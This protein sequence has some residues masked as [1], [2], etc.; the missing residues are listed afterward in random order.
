MSTVLPGTSDQLA[1]HH[2]HHGVAFVAAPVFGRP[3]AAAA[4]KVWIATSGPAGAKQRLSPVL[5][6]L[7]QGVFDFGD[8]PGAANI[9]KLATNFV[10]Y[11]SLESLAEASAF[12]E[13]QGIPRAA[14][15]GMLTGTLFNCYAYQVFSRRVIDAD[16]D[17]VSFNAALALKDLTLA[18]ETAS[19]TDTP[20]PILA[21]LCDRFASAIAKGRGSL[22]ASVLARGAAED[23]G[24]KW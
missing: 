9:V 21:L 12:A 4:R 1:A 7:G 6:A 17:Q 14:L 11:A 13:K 15:L 24:L 5:S 18:R 10:A 2:A 8:R 22:D 19:A 16:F 3:E 23:A 20:M